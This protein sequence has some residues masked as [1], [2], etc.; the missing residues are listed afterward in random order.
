MEETKKKKWK[1]SIHRI[2]HS[3]RSIALAAFRLDTE[4]DCLSEHLY[5]IGIYISLLYTFCDQNSKLDK[6]YLLS[7]T[8]LDG[9]NLYNRYLRSREL[10][11]LVFMKFIFNIIH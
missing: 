1:G 3:P 5:R 6:D 4:Y 7:F 10:T 8:L 2:S 11:Q 9:K